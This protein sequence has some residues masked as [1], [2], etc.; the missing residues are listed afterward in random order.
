M[1][2]REAFNVALLDLLDDG[3][4][5]ACADDP[6]AWTGDDPAEK[7]RAARICRSCPLLPHCA[8]VAVEEKHQHGV[9]AGV[10]FGDRAARKAVAS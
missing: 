6:D 1:T 8:A 5:L 10:D 2:A 9:W 3:G 4:K 7:A